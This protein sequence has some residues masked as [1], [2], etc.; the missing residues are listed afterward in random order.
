MFGFEPRLEHVFSHNLMLKPPEVIGPLPEGIRAN[1]YIVGGEVDGP[2]L[3]GK[4]RPVGGDWFTF[5]SDGVGIIDIRGTIEAD[6]GALIYSWHTGVSDAGEDGYE[7]FLR[8]DLPPV[9][10]PRIASRYSTVHPNY[11]WLNRLQCVGF[12]EVYLQRL[13]VRFDIYA[14]K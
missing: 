2:K 3:R 6:D 10:Q 11:R 8:Q 7:R 13:E 4:I 1:F 14:L 12:G 9:L 5:R